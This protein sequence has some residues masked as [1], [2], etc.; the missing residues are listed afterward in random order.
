[1]VKKNKILFKKNNDIN[2]F[3][4]KYLLSIVNLKKKLL[5]SLFFLLL[6]K[7]DF[8]IFFNKAKLQSFLNKNKTNKKIINI[9]I[10]IK[11]EIN[12]L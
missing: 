5:L 8:F 11:I 1:M 12:K 4:K 9:K 7:T 3:G 2:W 10:V 6:I